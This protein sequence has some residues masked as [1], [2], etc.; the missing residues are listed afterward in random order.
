MHVLGINSRD[1]NL[2][3]NWS[4]ITL[5]QAIEL[6][7][8]IKNMPEDLKDIYHLNVQAPKDKEEKK[9]VKDKLDKL[10]RL[11]T[12]LQHMKL[13]PKFYGKVLGAMAGIPTQVLNRIM[14]S[15]R[16]AVYQEYCQS[17][18]MGLMFWP[19]DI[20]L[21]KRKSFTWNKEKLLLPQ[22][23]E[24]MGHKWPMNSTTALEFCEAS[25][26]EIAANELAGG[27]WENAKWMIGILCRPEG[28]AYDEDKALA[29]GETMDELPMSIV[30][31]VFFC[32]TK[33]ISTLN[34]H[35]GSYLNQMGHDP[36]KPKWVPGSNAT[37]GT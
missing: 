19:L 12:P 16:M 3:E 1:Y 25:D 29:R 23:K 18:V 31:E 14:W 34:K 37:V 27:K 13:F 15:E 5:G 33:R 17:Y 35:M 22:A 8:A 2:P 20:K 32:G 6:N 26:M 24:K 30:W 9:A 11:I 36:R 28:E 7:K 4:E 10:Y 21:G